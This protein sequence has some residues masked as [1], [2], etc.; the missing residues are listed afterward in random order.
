MAASDIK[1]G[2]AY[3]E[4]ATDDKNLKNGLSKMSAELE[5][6]C[7][8]TTT[9]GMGAIAAAS[10]V[11]L[12]LGASMAVYANFESQMAKVA[13]ITKATSGEVK[14]L[15]EQAKLLGKTTFFSASQVADAQ[16]FLGMAGFNAKDIEAGLPS[17]LNLALAGNI[18]IGQAADIASNISTP[19]GIAA[20]DIQRVTD[21]LAT[22][23]TSSNTD[24][25]Q[26]GE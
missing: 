4:I 16:K 23:A 2:R 24:V 21:L 1:A 7:R 9:I 6:W 11:A 19:F 25:A 20:K 8:R 26:M 12:P 15:R 17:V 3:I 10:T 18:D 13:A 22:A 5:Q 14:N